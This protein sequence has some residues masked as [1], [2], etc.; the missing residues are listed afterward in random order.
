LGI[1]LPVSILNIVVLGN[2]FNKKLGIALGVTA[3]VSGLGGALFNPVIGA[4]ISNMGWHTG[5]RISALL[6][7]ICVLPVVWLCM[8]FAPGK[9]ET[10]Y[11]TEVDEK[12]D[13]EQAKDGAAQIMKGM[14]LKQAVH[15]L[16]F[17]L[18]IISG[19]ALAFQSGIMQLI[20]S[21]VTSIGFPLTVA[22]SVMSGV[23]IGIAA[24]KLLLGVLL[25]AMK[26]FVALLI[27]MIIGAAG[28]A[29]MIF[30]NSQLLMI[31]CGFLIGSAQAIMMVA[32]PYV[33]RKVFGAREF[34]RISSIQYMVSGIVPAFSIVLVGAI[35]DS[36]GSFNLPFLI[37]SAVV[38]VSIIL[39]ISALVVSAKRRAAPPD[40][41][42]AASVTE[43]N[44]VI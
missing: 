17:Y 43:S 15:S 7:A 44:S 31:A 35:F 22:A 32:V 29:G 33:S 10:A 8:R 25:D 19:A 6:V 3:A 1:A 36:T 20:S 14:T 9:G 16:V 27:Y 13:E 12:V 41:K 21:H 23:M 37:S 40:G 38:V 26:P 30:A 28:W 4:V 2:W 5:Y 34:S 24:G 39:M 11:G 18:M 42:A